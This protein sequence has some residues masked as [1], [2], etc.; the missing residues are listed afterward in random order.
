[1]MTIVMLNWK[2]PDNV[3]RIVPRLMQAKH[4][5]HVLIWDNTGAARMRFPTE[6]VT[7]IRS[8]KDMSLFTRFAAGALADTDAIMYHDDDVLIQPKVLDTLYKRWDADPDVLHTLFGRKLQKDGTYAAEV[9]GNGE[10]PLTLTTAVL[11]HKQYV[12][13]AMQMAYTLDSLVR[14]GR[15][16]GNGEDI[17]LSYAAMRASG[18]PQQVHALAYKRLPDPYAI[19]RRWG[20]HGKFRTQLCEACAAWVLQNPQAEA[21]DEVQE[22]L[23]STSKVEPVA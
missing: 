17:L 16:L 7:V 8:T 14:Q 1:M 22:Y 23:R 3:R 2:R 21:A 19:H 12:L 9:K 20:G 10:A 5:K 18:R 13:D 4:V 15:P 6:R 11:T